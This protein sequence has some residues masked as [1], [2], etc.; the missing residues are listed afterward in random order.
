L[1][2]KN[3]SSE[4]FISKGGIILVGSGAA[5]GLNMNAKKRMKRKGGKKEKTRHGKKGRVVSFR[6]VKASTGFKGVG[7]VFGGKTSGGRVAREEDETPSRKHW[8]LLAQ[9]MNKE[10]TLQAKCFRPWIGP[11]WRVL[12][13]YSYGLRR[14]SWTRGKRGQP[15]KLTEEE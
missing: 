9:N 15:P 10:R 2:E 14:T 8:D 6:G 13:E 5:R 3:Y 1:R 11:R 4:L 12:L 7:L